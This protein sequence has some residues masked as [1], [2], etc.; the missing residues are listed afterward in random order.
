MA[1]KGSSPDD[2]SGIGGRPQDS[3]VSDRL[4]GPSDE[5]A[6]TLR[7]SGLLG[8]SDRP[9]Q[10]RLYFN[11]QLDYYAEFA[12]AD[13]ISVQTVPSDQAPFVGLEATSVTLRRD[14]V[15][16]FTHVRSAAPVD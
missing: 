16:R 10:R 4:A 14:A 9:G 6:R 11:K 7:L 15:V 12:S 8:D 1:S 2:P 5:P 3:F 13:V